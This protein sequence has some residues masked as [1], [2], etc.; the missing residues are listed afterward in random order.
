MDREQRGNINSKLI[1][2]VTSTSVQPQLTITQL[3]DFPASGKTEKKSNS[4]QCKKKKS[5]CGDKTGLNSRTHN[6]RI[7]ANRDFTH[8]ICKLS[9]FAVQERTEF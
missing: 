2:I 9:C 8:F 4:F 1:N 7:Q 6:T 3:L 5:L